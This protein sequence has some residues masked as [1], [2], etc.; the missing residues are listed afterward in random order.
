MLDVEIYRGGGS[1]FTWTEPGLNTATNGA[2]RTFDTVTAALIVPSVILMLSVSSIHT[3]VH[4]AK[5]YYD[6]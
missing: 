3:H 1:S 5:F 6:T 4:D 2:E